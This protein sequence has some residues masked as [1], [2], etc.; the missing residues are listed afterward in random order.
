[1]GE[2]VGVRDF[3]VVARPDARRGHALVGVFLKE[4]GMEKVYER[5]AGEV[6]GLWSLQDWV[7]VSEL[8]VTEMGKLRRGEL[9]F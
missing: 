9:G 1:M 2:D 7:E 6:P 4:Y 3:A 8:P 5:I